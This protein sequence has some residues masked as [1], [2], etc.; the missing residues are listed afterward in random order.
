MQQHR[1]R[2][3]SYRENRKV[4]HNGCLFVQ[5]GISQVFWADA[6]FIKDFTKFDHLNVDRPKKIALFL[7]DIYDSSDIVLGSV[8]I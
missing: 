4:D 1:R 7:N 6:I 2:L 5:V 8:D 3:P